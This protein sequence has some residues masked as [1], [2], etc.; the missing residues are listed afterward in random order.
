[1]ASRAEIM[2]GLHKRDR[3]GLLDLSRRLTRRE[4]LSRRRSN[5]ALSGSGLLEAEQ[6]FWK[7]IVYASEP[8]ADILSQLLR[9]RSSQ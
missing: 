8:L 2:G 9:S 6:Q 5:R 7:V 4:V 1:M 3:V